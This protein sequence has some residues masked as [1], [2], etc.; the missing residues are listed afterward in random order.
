MGLLGDRIVDD[1]AGAL[2]CSPEVE[3]PQPRAIVDRQHIQELGQKGVAAL[4]PDAVGTLKLKAILLGAAAHKLL[5]EP[6]GS[7]VQALLRES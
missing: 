5:V 2:G 7:P 1:S 3:Q 4:A 6:V